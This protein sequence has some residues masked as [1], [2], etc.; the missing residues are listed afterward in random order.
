MNKNKTE[1][2]AQN[3]L[4]SEMSLQEFNELLNEEPNPENVKTNDDGY[5]HIPIAFLEDDL[6][7]CFEGRVEFQKTPSQMLFNAV[8]C[9][10]IIRVFHPVLKEFQTFY[11]PGT[12]MIESISQGKYADTTKVV[13]VNDESLATSLAFAEAKKS[14]ARQIGRRFGS[15]L[16]RNE[17]P[18]KISAYDNDQDEKYIF[19]AEKKYTKKEMLQ[20]V[21]AGKITTEIMNE[22]LNNRK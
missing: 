12:V 14:A 19:D 17:A 18:G 4:P 9:D 8:D 16:N 2:Q 1:S 11:G 5:R 13:K 7:K 6:R 3:K 20:L 10:A 15:D 22:Y 21:A